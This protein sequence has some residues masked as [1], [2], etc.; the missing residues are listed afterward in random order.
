MSYL[1]ELN[2]EQKKAVLHKDGPL[3]I[4]AGAG[5]GKT[6]T[7]SYRILH[8]IK[9]GVAPENILA[10]T[11][12][13][14]A[15]N[16]MKE[17]VSKLLKKDFISNISFEEEPFIKTFHSLGVY[18]LRE[19]FKELNISKYFS[20]LDKNDSQKIIKEIIISLDLD[21]KQI[22]PKKILGVI[23]KQ[24][25]NFI[26]PF[27]YESEPRSGSD[28][29]SKIISDVWIKYEERLNKEKSLDFDD[30]LLKTATLLKEKKD[31]LERY[32][33][34]WKYIH[35]DEY[36]DTNKVQYKI[37]KLLSGKNKNICV[38]GDEDQLIY[39]WRGA[40]IRNILNFEKDFSKSQ[41]I[42][43]EENY[44][45]TQNIL[46]A[47][48]KVIKKNSL[49][50]DKNL[51][52][53]NNA[54]EKIDL[55]SAYDEKDEANFI[56]LTAQDLI[57]NQKI[58]AQ[59]IAVLY[60]T[61]FQSRNLE[62]AFLNVGV[63]YQVLG[64]K[65]FDRKEIKDIISYIK[66]SLNSENLIDFKRVVNTPAR[67]IG[68]VTLA[69][70]FADKEDELSSTIQ[71]KIKNFRSLLIKIKEIALIKEPSILIKFI[72]QESGLGDKLKSGTEEDLERLSNMK[73]LV[74]LALKY[75]KMPIGEGIE[76]LLEDVA[77]MT[78]QDKMEKK[79]NAVKL[80]TVH[81][82]KGLE[83]DFVFIA[84]LEDELFP[85]KMYDKSDSN[86]EEEERRLFYVALTR[87]RKKLFLTY[88]SMRTIFGS[89]R[90]N[91]ISEFIT[92]ID[93]NLIEDVSDNHYTNSSEGS[94]KIEYLEW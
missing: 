24:K 37:A 56:A 43:L 26:T 63:P 58:P 70:I 2:S 77:L 68:K 21:P 88:T 86:Q 66:T 35:I 47:A 73:E 72:I 50:K 48:N 25:G 83:F 89:R 30:L 20:I 19:N 51:F 61:N 12:T 84:G 42:L 82:S 29:L 39:A 9:N 3:L 34:K 80:M 17:R 69:K 67:G 76:K 41:T 14:K 13:N 16:E 94:E 75:D 31:I 4:L 91:T 1:D 38:V 36:Q 40:S 93:D 10:V 18:I 22:E 45:S 62:E 8:L 15:A 11:F 90:T 78:D 52:T 64:T 33:K 54:G 44:R 46:A 81:A 27:D 79:T 85:S 49:R 5:A 55:Y 59:E 7:I 71:L 87:A 57:E 65:F 32:Q 28:F 6:R 53:K 23:S 92:D 60:R 74:S